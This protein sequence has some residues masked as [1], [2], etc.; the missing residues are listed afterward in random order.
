MAARPIQP[1]SVHRSAAW[2][3]VAESEV[4]SQ[5]ST[6]I[7]QHSYDFEETEAAIQASLSAALVELDEL[8]LGPT[9]TK[10]TPPQPASAKPKLTLGVAPKIPRGMPPL[11]GGRRMP[12]LPVA[13]R[14][15]L[16]PFLSPFQRS[17]RPSGPGPQTA[18]ARAIA[19]S[20]PPTR[21]PSLALDPPLR[22]WPGVVAAL[23]GVTLVGAGLWL[24][25]VTPAERQ[26]TRSKLEAFV[27]AHVR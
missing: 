23:L 15:S 1:V 13:L 22:R 7:K 8:E 17:K 11:P 10:P 21:A 5:S 3:S 19:M 4:P 27:H 26:W 18:A 25:L 9:A 2:R 24:S 6:R 16:T 12:P 14:R 20:P